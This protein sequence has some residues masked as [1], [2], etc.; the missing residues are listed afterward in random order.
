MGLRLASCVFFAAACVAASAGQ[1]AE[2]AVTPRDLVRATATALASRTPTELPFRRNFSVFDPT[3]LHR[4]S[5]PVFMRAPLWTKWREAQSG[6]REDMMALARCRVSADDCTM[7]A[8]Q[9]LNAIVDTAL[10]RTGRARIGEINRAVNLSIRPESDLK[11][12][13]AWDQWSAPLA[14]LA[15]GRGDCEDYAIAKLVALR[16]AGFEDDDL[17]LLIVREK[18]AQPDHAMAAVRHEGRWLVLDNR[19]FVMLDAS[20]LDSEI[21]F[22]LR[23]GDLRLMADAPVQD[24][25][26]RVESVS[27]DI[28]IVTGLPPVI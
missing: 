12:H 15:A 6:I 20:E 21:L 9:H 7:P 19:K 26:L 18:S 23:G 28:T 10:T 22:V 14:T 16:Q 13:G 5:A 11:Q 4:T 3:Q 27:D 24:D 1:A 8:A 2:Q 25:G 17:R